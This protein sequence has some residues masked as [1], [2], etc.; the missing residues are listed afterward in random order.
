M[1][2]R[3]RAMRPVGPMIGPIVIGGKR[4]ALEALETMDETLIREHVV[5]LL[6]GTDAHLH[7]IWGNWSFS[8]DFLAY[9]KRMETGRLRFE[10]PPFPRRV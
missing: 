6:G 5:K 7:I 4:N 9:G 1:R 2:C 10:S 3:E 8:E